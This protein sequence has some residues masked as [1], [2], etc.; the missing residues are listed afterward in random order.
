[1][2]KKKKNKNLLGLTERGLAAEKI[3][4]IP[5]DQI[6]PNENNHATITEDSIISMRDSLLESG[7]LTPGDA[8]EIGDD[9]YLLL[10][11]HRRFE[12]LKRLY[13]E[14]YSD[15]KGMYLTVRDLEDSKQDWVDEETYEAYRMAQ[16]NVSRRD[17]P[18]DLISKIYAF[19]DYFDTFKGALGTSNDEERQ[20]FL[21]DDRNATFWNDE[22]GH[23]CGKRDYLARRLE[24][25]TGTIQRITTLDKKLIEPLHQM[26]FIDE[27]IPMTIA[28]EIA[29][30]DTRSQETAARA[31]EKALKED[32]E[33]ISSERWSKIR[34]FKKTKSNET[35][36]K[37]VK[38]Q[39][40]VNMSDAVYK[41]LNNTIPYDKHLRFQESDYRSVR[42]LIKTIDK[43][44]T[45]LQTLL[46]SVEGYQDSFN[47]N[48]NE[49]ED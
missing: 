37:P 10:S 35:N 39:K 45:E 33:P 5:L 28:L 40:C 25:G 19:G 26:Y 23:F 48:Q 9:R 32:P 44:K 42:R 8:R 15:Y 46:A 13:K 11:G 20:A 36:P 43:K 27:V 34:R 49:L 31:I 3:R 2:I 38:S 16:S 47:Q 12:G 30:L 29:E 4:F 6:I 22:P 18:A 14:G 21:E 1:M 24:V 7:Q 41:D 17:K